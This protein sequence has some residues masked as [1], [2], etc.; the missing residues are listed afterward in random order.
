MRKL[1]L[2]VC[3]VLIPFELAV[4]AETPRS[5]DL[6]RAVPTDAYLAIYGRHNPERDFQREYYKAVCDTVRE[7]RIIERAV[8]IV[9]SR[10]P[11]NDLEK[12]ESVLQELR[13]AAAPIDIA[14]IANVKEAVYAQM[15]QVPSAQHLVLLRLGP[16]AAAS[17]EQGIKNL[18]GLAEKYSEGAL[19]IQTD[20]EGDTEL[21]T[22]AFPQPVPF[23]PT[24]ARIDDI[25]LFASSQQVAR[26][27]LAML[28]GKGGESKFDDPRLKE[29][30]KRLPEPE[31]CLT[32][33]DGKLQ[34]SQMRGI[35]KFIRQASGGDAGAERIAG[36]IELVFDEVAV[37][38]Y[39]VTVEYTEENRN[40][41][42]VFGRLLPGTEDKLLMKVLGSGQP[43][44]DWPRWVPADA[45]AFS[46]TSG[47]NLHPLYERII[48]VLQER[49][50]EAEVG[51]KQFE[52]VQ[53]NFDLHLDRDLL[54]AFSGECVSITLPLA[55]PAGLRTA[56]SLFALRCQRPERIR[57]LLHR[58]VDALKQIPHV[59]T[60]QL[61]LAACER[62]EGFEQLSASML[63]A[64]GLR[65]V[66]GFRDGWMVVASDAS[67]VQ[68]VFDA[69][70]GKGDA[71]TD[72]ESFKRFE[73]RVD[74]PVRSISYANTAEN[75]RRMA[76]ML[77]QVG[78]AIPMV[79]AMAGAQAD[80]ET[81]K[82][83]QEIFGLLPS[84]AKIVAKFDFLEA[85]L[86]V[87]QDGDEP[88]TYRRRSVTLVRP[89]SAE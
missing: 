87:T 46:L 64:F 40:C 26:Q 54:Q 45:T 81:M 58:L 17:C 49:V 32:F 25:L 20:K 19:P 31:D 82:P 29:A 69:K 71:I 42:A 78:A 36:L 1:V 7:T 75:T 9:T 67:A 77:N 63:T 8:A 56:D 50:P 35:G 48:A 88:N 59:Q 6:R 73:L 30:L 74:G 65:P 68:R 66:I 38:D 21:T 33:Y 14:A 70:A 18:F 22:L 39:E 60:Q 27:S 86:S 53:S 4:S 37:L 10:I 89:K 44:E 12:A 2:L 28:L 83:A 11:A 34:F 23:R 80:P 41:T 72:A 57:E 84:V 47:V 79:M 24:V 52:Q 16:E 51:L 3:F 13:E 55:A 5:L 76:A 62:L 61:Q 43:F 85:K 15:M